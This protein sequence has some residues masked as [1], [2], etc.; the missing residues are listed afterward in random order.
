MDTYFA[1]NMTRLREAAGLSQAE[2]VQ[3]LR[4]KGWKNVHPTTISRIEKGERPVRL[5]EAA[6]IAQVLGQDLQLMM[7]TPNRAG[8]EEEV[9]K[10]VERVV[11]RY[12]Q[13]VEGAYWLLLSRVVLRSKL[14]K[15]AEVAEREDDDRLR[16]KYRESEPYLLLR[17]DKAVR[18]AREAEAR[19][20][21]I[22]TG[23]VLEQY[24]VTA[25]NYAPEFID[26]AELNADE[27]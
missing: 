25:H 10:A 4:E 15:L 12:N 5:S 7:I 23:S 27:A 24:G 18:A 9:D 17:I 14:R 19:P 1:Q 22:G 20:G 11:K 13:I 6:R 26:E 3:K 8:A 2:M 16:Q 21:G